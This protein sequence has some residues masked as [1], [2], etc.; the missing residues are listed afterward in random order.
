MAA[1]LSPLFRPSRV[2]VVGASSNPEKM[3]FQIFRNI[4]EAGYAGEILPVNP[5]GETVLGVPS[6]TS[7]AGIP[8]GTDLAVV[9]IPAKLVPGTI[10][11]LGAR[12][13]KSAIVITGGFAESGEEGAKL[14]EEIIK[15]AKTPEVAAK[16]AP[17]G[18]E[19]VASTPEELQKRVTSEREHWS[20]QI[21]AL[22]IKV[23]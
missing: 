7:A 6:V 19:I 16:V 4:R 11:E 9:I 12:K 5:K 2:A 15:A 23:D 22:G 14:Q 3:G 10:R 18:V 13:V 20:K 21:K 1:P 8:E 17:L